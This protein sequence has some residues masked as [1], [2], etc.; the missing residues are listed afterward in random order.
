MT[1]VKIGALDRALYNIEA[2]TGAWLRYLSG[3]RALVERLGIA[4]RRFAE[5]FTWDNAATETEAHLREVVGKE[6]GR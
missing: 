5:G 2:W 6:V 4:A 3:E 1:G